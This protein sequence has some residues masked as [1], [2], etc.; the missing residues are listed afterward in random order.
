MREVNEMGII[1]KTL[2]FAAG[3]GLGYLCFNPTTEHCQDLYHKEL[4]SID[5]EYSNIPRKEIAGP[6]DIGIE[7]TIFKNEKIKGLVFTDKQSGD[8]G[9]LVRRSL[10]FQG[11]SRLEYVTL[12]PSMST[13]A[14]S[15]SLLDQSQQQGDATDK[16]TAPGDLWNKVKEYAREKG[17][18]L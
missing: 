15:F 8:R 10:L 2:L 9:I 12:E 11:K 14:K 16:S 4:R 13:P 7:Y 5:H 1:G 3:V 18:S 17:I 6:E